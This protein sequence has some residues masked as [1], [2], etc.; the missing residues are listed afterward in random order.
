MFDSIV[1]E[2]A[3]EMK[4]KLRTSIQILLFNKRSDNMMKKK[5]LMKSTLDKSR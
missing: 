2:Y 3:R 4:I 1:F 5:K